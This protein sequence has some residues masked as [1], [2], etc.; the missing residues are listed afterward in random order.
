M[1][2]FFRFFVIL[3]SFFVFT[4]MLN[5]Q[6]ETKY[7]Y[8]PK[9]IYKNQ[10][11]PVTV[12]ILDVQSS[13]TFQFTFDKQSSVKPLFETPLMIENGHDRF[14]TF[15]FKAG[16]KDIRIPELT[17]DSGTHQTVLPSDRIPISQLEPNKDFSGVLAAGMKIINS[18]VSNYDENNHIVTL[19]IEA[20]EANL[21]DMK[22]NNVIEN[23]IED[24]ERENAKVRGE[25][26]AVLPNS[27]NVLT[28]SYFNT[29]NNQY[30]ALTVPVEV[31][32]A[33][34]VAHS[35]LN[36]KE[37]SFEELK[38]YT[39]L[40]LVG[41]FLFM[42][43]FKRD[44]F[45]LV[46]GTV[47]FI[48]LLTLFIPHKKVCIKQGAPLYILP[49]HTSTISTY[50]DHDFE[51]ALLGNREPYLKIEYKEGIVGWIKNEDLCK[52]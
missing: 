45:Y 7:S 17:I 47:S 27:Q 26:Y 43:L 33:T 32:D 37:D 48:T 3:L 49:T 31:K 50:V 30:N 25:L 4:V 9:N 19:S 46:L 6:G 28:F 52:N 35:E 14:Y 36:P 18:Q 11:F 51:T 42:F 41:F 22:L 40:F 16:D 21:E 12:I 2:S 8:F 5:A 38:K 1:I 24:V 34:V 15:Y 20:N 39:L 13:E 10:V 44:F 29:I 23:G